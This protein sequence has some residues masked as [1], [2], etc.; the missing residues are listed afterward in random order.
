MYSFS[1]IEKLTHIA[2][3]CCKL[4]IGTMIG[5]QIICNALIMFD[6]YSTENS[7]NL[8]I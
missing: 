1:L 5:L 7:T 6:L 8:Y 3:H 4:Y 2:K